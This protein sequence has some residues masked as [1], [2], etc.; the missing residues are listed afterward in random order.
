MKKYES[1]K[2]S[3]YLVD[4]FW[5]HRKYTDRKIC[6]MDLKIGYFACANKKVITKI[7]IS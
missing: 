2:T 6:S 3:A 7:F 5:W 4:G 1:E